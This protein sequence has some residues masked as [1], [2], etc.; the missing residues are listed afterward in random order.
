MHETSRG[1]R[2][3]LQSTTESHSSERTIPQSCRA[4]VEDA[5]RD[6][7]SGQEQPRR[8]DT[9]SSRTRTS[10]SS[11]LANALAS[12][13]FTDAPCGPAV[14]VPPRAR[15][16]TPVPARENVDTPF[17]SSRSGTTDNDDDDDDDVHEH[18]ANENDDDGDDD[19]DVDVVFHLRHSNISR[20]CL[21][22]TVTR[23]V[24]WH[25][26][27]DSHEQPLRVP[28]IRA[29]GSHAGRATARMGPG[30]PRAI[31]PF[32]NAVTAAIYG[33]DEARIVEDRPRLRFL[34]TVGASPV[35]SRVTPK[36]GH[37]R[38][39]GARAGKGRGR[40][41]GRYRETLEGSVTTACR[42]RTIPL[43]NTVAVARPWF[44]VDWCASRKT[45]ES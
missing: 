10:P 31:G 35:T 4:T 24:D 1:T 22:T 13:T 18:V 37:D 6:I 9:C 23:G 38:A 44:W 29:R 26:R 11:T 16:G 40:Y 19:N 12:L 2:L 32:V 7:T 41:C 45:G 42:Q 43:T 25:T 14:A 8:N 33:G 20:N 34:A 27:A 36:R 17:F 39:H 5:R 30:S 3:I 28:T 21:R 15:G